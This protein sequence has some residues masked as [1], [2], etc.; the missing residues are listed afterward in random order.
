VR[1]DFWQKSNFCEVL[2]TMGRIERF[3]RLAA[4][5]ALKSVMDFKH[6]AGTF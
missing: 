4:K 6:G 2:L 3:I 1:A 5:I